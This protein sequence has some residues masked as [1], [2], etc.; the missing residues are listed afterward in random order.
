[1]GSVSGGLG[2][3]LIMVKLLDDWSRHR[4][5]SNKQGGSCTRVD[6]PDIKESGTPEGVPRT[7]T[8]TEFQTMPEQ[9]QNAGAP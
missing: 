6:R 7:A 9:V 3:G 2:V 1:V 5:R 4:S 8:A